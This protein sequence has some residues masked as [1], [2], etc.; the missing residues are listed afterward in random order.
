MSLMPMVTEDLDSKTKDELLK[1]LKEQIIVNSHLTFLL[2]N[3]QQQSNNQLREKDAEIATLRMEL[4]EI[5]DLKTTIKNLRSENEDLRARLQH[6]EQTNTALE[7]R[8]RKV[9]SDF[10]N[11]RHSLS[12]R[13]YGNRADR[14]AIKI[15]FPRASQRPYCIRSFSNLVAFVENP[16]N[17]EKMNLCLPGAKDI[18][19]TLEESDRANIHRKISNLEAA[20][21]ELQY[22]IKTLKDSA[23]D[24]AHSITSFEETSVHFEDDE[25]MRYAIGVCEGLLKC[26]DSIS[27]EVDA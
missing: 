13:E 7:S 4:R 11:I 24:A 21:P 1:I 5:D 14:K 12:A 19:D 10:N 25:V 2:G 22:S 16:A 3:V 6:L 8:V 27:S 9:E 15:V 23:N 26:G 18:W 20:Y 17:A